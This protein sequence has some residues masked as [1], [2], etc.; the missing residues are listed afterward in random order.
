M[1][2]Q[3]NKQLVEFLASL[4][5]IHLSPQQVTQYQKDL[6]E[7]INYVSM[8]G[9]MDTTNVKAKFHTTNKKNTF[10]KSNHPR[11]T[12]SQAQVLQNAKHVKQNMFVVPRIIT[13]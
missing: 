11:Q 7:I 8:I 2:T 6:E 9:Q 4:G 3:V 13:K 5:K 10:Q 12:L 1:Q